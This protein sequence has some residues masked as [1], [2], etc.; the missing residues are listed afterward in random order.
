MSDL[1]D[2]NRLILLEQAVK[3]LAASVV[4]LK[5]EVAKLR[6]M[7]SLGQGALWAVMKL[8]ALILLVTSVIEVLAGLNFFHKAGQ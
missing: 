8:G 4:E 3:N 2:D 6:D 1:S 7:A 5:T